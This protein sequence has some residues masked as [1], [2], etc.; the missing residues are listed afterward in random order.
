MRSSY[1]IF[2]FLSLFIFGL[3]DNARG[4]I[5]PKVIEAFGISN[6]LS[7]WIFTLTS[8]VSFLITLASP[9]WLKRMGAVKA[10]KAAIAFHGL[11]LIVMGA[12][13]IYAQS[14]S[15]FLVAS[16]IL[17]LAMGIQSV[18]LNLIISRVSTPL[19]GRKLFSGL[20]AM[21]G[22]ASFLSLIHI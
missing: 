18:T 1:I 7:S 13:S 2:S 16:A 19:N 17:G 9:R 12:S 22:A 15:L 11:A 3:I 20:H 8:L 10:S 21:Y 14:F 6:S 4:P 5:Y